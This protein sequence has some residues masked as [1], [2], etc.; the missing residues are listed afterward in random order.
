MSQTRT[1]SK[2]NEPIK[3]TM[4]T[5]A[6][7]NRH[8]IIEIVFST[9]QTTEVRMTLGSKLSGLLPKSDHSVLE[10]KSISIDLYSMAEIE[11]KSLS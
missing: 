6:R 2:Q 7:W 11:A 1:K 10:L 3:Y 4:S 5:R 8:G 9:R